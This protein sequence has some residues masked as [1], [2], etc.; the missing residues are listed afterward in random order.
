MALSPINFAPSPI[1]GPSL[2]AP[3]LPSPLT[4]PKD[5]NPVGG[6]FM[7][8]LQQTVG[9]E[10]EAQ[11]AIETGLLGGDITQAEVMASVKKADLS[12]R[13]LMQVRNKV[14]GAYNEIQAMKF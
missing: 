12:V 7:E 1:G 10:H 4:P 6:A 8:M 2:T 14:I 11:A 5:A 9:A 13:M 3:T